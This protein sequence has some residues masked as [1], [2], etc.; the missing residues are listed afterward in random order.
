MSYNNVFFFITIFSR[1]GS[2]IN[3]VTFL[4][5]GS[6]IFWRQYQSLTIKKR[7]DGGKRSK[8]VQNCVTSFMPLNFWLIL[9]R[10]RLKYENIRYVI[11]ERSLTW[12]V[13]NFVHPKKSLELHYIRWRTRSPFPPGELVNDNDTF[14]IF[15]C[16]FWDSLFFYE[17]FLKNSVFFFPMLGFV[18]EWL[19][20]TPQWR[21]QS[22]NA[23]F[24]RPAWEVEIT[25]KM[26]DFEKNNF[27][28]V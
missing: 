28:K 18:L 5:T 25:S 11:Y 10:Q 9:T 24:A 23:P 4:G 15:V 1:R 17:L 21:N 8:I 12:F 27:E 20:F 26:I 3:D 2:F 6:K 22:F 16:H 13:R 19:L 14:F 7:Y